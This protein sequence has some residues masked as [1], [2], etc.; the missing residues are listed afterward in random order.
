[1]TTVTADSQLGSH[2]RESHRGGNMNR[3]LWMRL[4]AAL[5][6]FALIAAAC[7]GDDDDE[8]SGDDGGS[9]CWAKSVAAPRT[10]MSRR[11]CGDVNAI[12]SRP[13]STL[14]E[15]A[16]SILANPHD[17]SVDHEVTLDVLA[18]I[19]TTPRP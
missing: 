9:D 12:H 18:Q 6:A 14:P 15:P 19:L 5:F 13:P 7:G 16:A 17:V 11:P 3:S 8:G 4:L 10:A 2:P 1:M